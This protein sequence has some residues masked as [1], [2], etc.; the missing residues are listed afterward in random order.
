MTLD[1]VIPAYNT[2][3]FIERAIRSGFASGA[4]NVIVVDDGSLD[5]TGERARQ[6]GATVI[7]QDNAGTAKARARGIEIATSEFVIL[8]DA[9]DALIAE[10]VPAAL[11]AIA[12]TDCIGLVCRNRH[13]G[14]SGVQRSAVRAHGAITAQAL[15]ELGYTPGP[16][17]AWIWRR[18]GILGALRSGPTPLDPPLA[19]DYELILRCAMAGPIATSELAICVYTLGTGKS[20]Q[21]VAQERERDRIQRYYADQLDLPVPVYTWADRRSRR[22]LDA[23]SAARDAG[24]RLRW[25]LLGL[26]GVVVKPGALVIAV[27]RRVTSVKGA[28]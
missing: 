7:R 1:V 19:E 23:A 26:A 20:R 21:A 17:G 25:L 28:R 11:A 22:Y 9:D 16:P 27:R 24:Q 10:N 14:P 3:G 15:L 6:A 5:A 13:Q 4:E 18:E 2:A 12:D 8:L